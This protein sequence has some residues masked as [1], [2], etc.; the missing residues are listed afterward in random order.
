LQE[1]RRQLAAAGLVLSEPI[2][3][4]R[5]LGDGVTG[6]AL[7]ACPL[8]PPPGAHPGFLADRERKETLRAERINEARITVVNA[9]QAVAGQVLQ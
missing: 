4:S 2:D 6:V 5:D 7:P 8:P 9:C 1:T 3:L